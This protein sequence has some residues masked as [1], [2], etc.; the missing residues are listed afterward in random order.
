[1]VTTRWN[2]K[3]EHFSDAFFVPDLVKEYAEEGFK[4]KQALRCARDVFKLKAELRKNRIVMVE[5]GL[6]YSLAELPDYIKNEIDRRRQ[7][8]FELTLFYI[9]PERS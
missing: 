1:M 7:N 4:L 2:K 3:T 5:S 9:I 6:S 8:N